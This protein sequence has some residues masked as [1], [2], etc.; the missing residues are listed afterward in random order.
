VRA[1]DERVTRLA[2]PWLISPG[3]IPASVP[4]PDS[5]ETF[6]PMFMRS[7]YGVGADL[8]RSGELWREL[9]P[10]YLLEAEDRRRELT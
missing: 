6:D 7:L 10:Y 5:Q 1:K 2:F 9:S 8:F 3:R 4:C